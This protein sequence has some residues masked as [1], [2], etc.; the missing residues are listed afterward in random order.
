MSANVRDLPVP[1]YTD[2]LQQ[3]RELMPHRIRRVLLVGSRYDFFLLWEDGHHGQLPLTEALHVQLTNTSWITPV[4]TREQALTACREQ[5]FDLV[6]VTPHIRD[7]GPVEMGLELLE[8]HPDLAIVPIV[9]DD[10]E[11]IELRQSPEISRFERPYLWQGDF[12]LLLGIVESI[13]DRRNVAPDT[14][15]AGVSV[16]ILIE[17]SV[18][19]YSSY[20]PVIYAALT[21]QSQ[22]VI[23][24]GV[25]IHH[26]LMR[27]RA[28]PK[29]IHCIS[30]EEAED[31]LRRYRKCLLGVISDINFPR[32]GEND[33]NAGL[34][35]ARMVRE[36]IPDLPVL[37]QTNDPGLKARAEELEASV[38]LKGSPTLMEEVGHFM[39]DRFGFGNFVFRTREGK[40]VGEASDL[41]GLE[42]LLLEA[43]DEVVLYHA[44]RNHFSTW[45]KARTEFGLAE[46]LKKAS[47]S[48]FDS[49]ELVRSY[50]V[51]SIR[52]HRR[53]R[54]GGYI[55][56]F[57]P[58]EFNPIM[59]FARIGNGSLGGKARGLGFVRSLLRDFHLRK[60]FP[61]TAIFVP[62]AL[63]LATDVFD[64]FMEENELLD[65]A[66]GDREDEA[67]ERRFVEAHLPEDVFQS[68]L[69]FIDIVRFPLAVRSSSLLEDSQNFSLTGVYRTYMVANS[70]PDRQVRVKELVNAIK[71]VYASTFHRCVKDCFLGSHYR[72]EEEKMAVIIQRVVGSRHESRFYPDFSGTARSYNFYPVAPMK[73]A[74][75]IARVALGLGEAV[76]EGG[77][78][79]SFSPRY[80]EK[81][82]GFTTLDQIL[83]NSQTE[84]Y[85]LELEEP[86][87]HPDPSLEP[88]LTK[89]GL[90]I[91]KK[92]GKLRLIGSTYS[93]DNRVVYDGVARPGVPIVSFSSVL[94]RRMFPL[95]PILQT[96]M[97]ISAEAM[98]MPV[99]IEFAVNLEVPEGNRFEFAF[100]QLRPFALG[101]GTEEVDLS[102]ANLDLAICSSKMVLG[103]GTVDDIRD[104]IVV[105]RARFDRSRSVE[106]AQQVANFNGTML[107]EKTP[108]L[109]IGVGRWG[110]ADPWLGIPV[111]WPQISGARVIIEADFRDMHTMPSQ[112]SHFF[113]NITS[114]G[115]GYFTVG[116]AEEVGELDWDW[117]AAQPE[118]RQMEFV[119]HVRLDRPLQILMDGH[120]GR[121]LV[122]RAKEEE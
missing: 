10:P 72:L 80:P 110:S 25:N 53:G 86:D 69:E 36:T 11:L 95:A 27:L 60:P 121:G 4:S 111:I 18:H 35:F 8:E 44:E 39:R 76:V 107:K 116:G 122:L 101:S 108:Y 43:A 19:Y 63:V 109:L 24:E 2:P 21:R 84:F 96:L 41:R 92:D 79:L 20:L 12:R 118:E 32:G 52:D 55:A 106:V 48:D 17:D 77:K 38:L 9:F 97:Q 49:T 74:D 64:R 75:G 29:I 66:L 5:K 54:Q 120:T 14:E 6:V 90:E 26:K 104:I 94:K 47:T 82:I 56:Y 37:L 62:S 59:S 30:Y 93:P 105:D 58:L 31:C 98:N 13:E 117:L 81:P 1:E 100:L 33:R 23:S 115:V 51:G 112:G 119:R 22:R 57:N 65:F 42:S 73:A 67:I 88:H 68:L 7:I 3:F 103:N 46:A 61:S 40:M 28:R 34:D 89:Y 91:A 15:S 71:R 70:H 114:S 99:E 87:S 83:E 102:Q 16:I 78:A 113:Q 50:L 85:A 45:L